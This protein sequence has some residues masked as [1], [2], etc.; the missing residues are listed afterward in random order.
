LPDVRH[1]IR[2]T[3]I[4]ALTAG[5]VAAQ[6]CAP[7][8]FVLE[9][10]TDGT[11]RAT[12]IA[13]CAPYAAATVTHGTLVFGEQTGRDGDLRLDLPAIPGGGILAVTV[14]GVATRVDLPA[15]A[16][17]VP[18]IA[19]VIWQD[20]PSPDLP[21]TF[22]DEA[23]LTVMPERLGFPG[24]RPQVDLIPGNATSLDFPITATSCDQEIDVR[25]V[26]GADVRDLAVT[27]PACDG[28]L[29]ALRIP[30]RP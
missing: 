3:G 21:V 20:F 9:N 7:R 30:L 8:L 27:L 4:A 1:L 11:V 22:A 12:Y 14:D 28:P 5:S 29:G 26:M 15:P 25:I 18:D 10:G 13:P 19:A 2:A 6:D 24:E 17:P 16:G 23:G